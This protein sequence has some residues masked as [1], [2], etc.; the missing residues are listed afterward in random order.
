M[1][2][3][4]SLKEALRRVL[5][6]RTLADIESLFR[7]AFGLTE[8]Q[9]KGARGIPGLPD[10]EAPVEL[11][12]AAQMANPNYDKGG[13][14]ET[15]CQRCVVAYELL[16]R[17]YIVFAKPN[18]NT[19]SRITHVVIRNGSECFENPIIHGRGYDTNIP[20][21]EKE[22]LRSLNLLPNGARSSIFWITP[23]GTQGHVIVCEKNAGIPIFVDA[24]TGFVGRNALGEAS[25]LNGYYWY[26]MDNLELNKN[27][28]WGEVVE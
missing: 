28:P 23:D 8:A 17:G 6:A 1:R 18:S 16:R 3:L 24:Q 21:R 13:G 4:I 25:R 11:T 5:E 9:I 7:D 26:R 2:L 10:V 12:Q 27:F 20:I 19:S 14:Y 15:N 22:L